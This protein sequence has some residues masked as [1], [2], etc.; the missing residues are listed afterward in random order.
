MDVV[1][2]LG[3]ATS[4]QIREELHDP[5]HPAAVRTLLR[6][7]E[8]K[9][10]LRHTKDGP[11]HVYAPTTPRS[12]AQRSPSGTCSARSLAARAPRQSRPCSTTATSRSPRASATRWQRRGQA[13][14]RRGTL[15]VMYAPPATF[16]TPADSARAVADVYGV[17][18]V[19]TLPVIAAV[20]AFVCL[21][22]SNAGTRAIIWRCT[23]A[24]LLAF[25]PAAS[26]RG[27]G[28][29]GSCR[30][31]S[32]RPLVAL[33][34]VQLDGPP[35]LIDPGEPAPRVSGLIRGLLVLYWTGVAIVLLRTVVARASAR[36]RSAPR[37]DAH[38]DASGGHDCVRRATRL[39]S[40]RPGCNSCSRRCPGSDHVGRVAPGRSPP[41]AA[42]RWPADRLQAVLRHELVHVRARDAAMRLTA[43]VACALFWFHPG[44]WWLARRFEADAEEACDDRVLLSGIRVSD[45][46][47]W[48]GASAP[49][50]RGHHAQA[51]I[52][53]VRPGNLRAR[54]AAVTDTRRRRRGSRASCSALRRGADRGDRRPAGDSAHWHRRGTC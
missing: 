23:L 31:C 27:N 34:T 22:Q 49:G 8:T 2:R 16:F 4:R 25:T 24:G 18:L 29:R 53:L 13:P 42:L 40:P 47:E 14:P 41:T 20:V 38:R 51:A 10:Q 12:V 6:I 54:L 1:Y 39:V 7:L 30:N 21:R 37:R 3:G 5:P 36:G 50:A 43:R 33:G 15:S 11:R 9:G 46:A 44:A 28:W 45:Y 48:L 19:A 17:S 26:C 35:G 32:P 52:A